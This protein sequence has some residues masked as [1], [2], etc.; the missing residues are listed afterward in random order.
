MDTDKLKE[1]VDIIEGTEVSLVEWRNGEER[2]T[3]RR[4][5][6]GSVSYQ[7]FAPNV[8]APAQMQLMGNASGQPAGGPA[9]APVVAAPPKGQ[10][11]TS[12]FVGTFYRSPSP[13]LPSFVEVN[14]VI[15]AGQ[16]LCIVEA[17]KLMN[18][19]E[20]ECSM[21][22]LEVLVENGQPVEYGEPLFL[23]EQA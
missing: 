15:A 9:S 11:I 22:V 5:Q 21:R 2:W 13:D 6:E 18:E 23:Y 19:I 4:G 12:P 1:I 10:Q 3:V 7:S 16:T 20:A 8:S 14:Q 17:M